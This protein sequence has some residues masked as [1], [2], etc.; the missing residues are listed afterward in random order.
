MSLEAISEKES[1][2]SS[3]IQ[4]KANEAQSAASDLWQSIRTIIGLQNQAP[5]LVPISRSE[6]IA[7]SFAQERLW[8]LDQL[9]SGSAAYNIPFAFR[10]NGKLNQIALEQSLKTLI[11][12]HEPLRT[13]FAAVDNQPMQVV[14]ESPELPL[15]VID[16]SQVVEGDRSS[17]AMQQVKEEAQ[18]LFDLTQDQLFRVQ[19]IKLA[20]EEY[21]LSL[22]VHHIVFDGWSEGIL[23]Q[24]LS[25]FYTA[26]VSGTTP[27]VSPLSIQYADFSVWQR[28]WL[29]GELLEALQRY[30][31]KQLSGNLS[32]LKLPIDHPHPVLKTRR[33]ACEKFVI[34]ETLTS[35][36][37]QLSRQ[38]RATLFP[39]VLA[40]FQVLL[41]HYT[42]QTDLFVCT[43]TANRNRSELKG[44]IGYFV[45]LLVLRSDLSGNPSFRELLERVRQTTSA[46]SAHQDLP[47]QQLVNVLDS[48]QISFSQVL[49]A[50]QNTPQQS[51]ELG[52]LVI[53]P[54]EIDSGT[55]DFDL[56]LSLVET[57]GTLVG[58]LKYNTD[59][60]DGESIRQMLNHFQ[61]VLE[62]IVADPGQPLSNL[63]VLSTEKQQLL[64]DK[65]KNAE[66][67]RTS[68]PLQSSGIVDSPNNALELQLVQIWEQVFNHSSIGIQDNF[69]ELGGNSMLAAR[70]LTCIKQT[71]GKDLPIST[72]LQAPTVR[73]LA[74]IL[75]QEGWAEPWKSLI[76]IQ[77]NGSKKPLFLIHDVYGDVLCFANLARHL[78]S[79]QPTYGLRP[80]G[81]NGD[82][83]PLTKIKDMAQH[84]IKEIKAVQPE[85]PYLLGGMCAGG[86]V[87]FEMAQQLQKQ[88]EK[89]DLL[90]VLNSPPPN[91]LNFLLDSWPLYLKFIRLLVHVRSL[92]SLSPAKWSTYFSERKQGFQKVANLKAKTDYYGFKIR[93]ANMKALQNYM[94]RPY[95]G[96]IT[97]FLASEKAATY[98]QALSS[99]KA[100]REGWKRLA[101]R[102]FEV[103][104]VP[105]SRDTFL[106]EPNAKDLAI[107]VG[108]YLEP[109]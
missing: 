95:Q 39:T 80:V 17:L 50:L 61:Q 106:R 72:L 68:Q 5:P 101:A 53:E 75:R 109:N 96:K 82:E 21:I 7:A 105:G 6:A 36:L 62:T 103:H 31:Q 27:S 41:Y 69:F 19:L 89:V 84:Y 104:E 48:K 16:L 9:E 22:T 25:N 49:F 10:I 37:K 56:F 20:D 35:S 14:H 8:L 2:S 42:E 87:A 51:L 98:R 91:P 13:T 63:L 15:S 93:L 58:T 86:V 60:F 11:A 100:I 23:L 107:Q 40:A 4:V 28:Q 24:E 45:N 108:A 46:A 12:R 32:D 34:S 83:P 33:S 76:P 64:E 44:L 67:V 97:L 3:S 92:L 71:F 78:G 54:I 30:W 52:D 47:I 79:D 94:P 90:A 55:A 66:V 57:S 18:R 38:E 1:F 65:R 102:G 77:P 70:L 43:P 88:G 74:K 73:E 59:L 99:P 29:Q 81:A 85:G 26:Y